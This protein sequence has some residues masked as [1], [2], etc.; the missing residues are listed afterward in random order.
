MSNRNDDFD[1]LFNDD[2]DF[3]QDDD[4][5]FRG[6]DLGDDDLAPAEYDI[7][8][9]DTFGGG[10][11]VDLDA[12]LFNEYD[13]GGDNIDLNL[14]DE[15]AEDGGR[16]PIF[17]IAAVLLVLVI[18]GGGGVL[19]FTLLNNNQQS[20]TIEQTR[21]A[22]LATNQAVEA[23]LTQT[24]QAVIS[25]RNATATADAFTDT[26]TP[27]LTPSDTPTPT[28][29]VGGTQTAI[30]I[31]T[32][33]A[34]ASS[35]ALAQSIQQTAAANLNATLTAQAGTAIAQNVTPPTM[36]PTLTPSE[37]PEG[38]TPTPQDPTPTIEDEPNGGVPVGAV[39]QTATALALILRPD[40]ITPGVSTP[41]GGRATPTPFAD[42]PNTGIFDDVVGTDPSLIMLLAFGLLGVIFVSRGLRVA[43]RK[44]K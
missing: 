41:V 40:L 10:D 32:A 37:T 33:N 9:F 38:P 12:D 13:R 1:N 24:E 20:E 43:N 17:I 34:Q 27:S 5:L 22:I 44:R 30:A 11:D 15:P 6:A 42:L 21:V 26:P 14:E 8:E 36:A 23:A 35:T 29:D 19:I 18:L 4:D 28:V 16:S 25:A 39:E 2:D 31:G 3:F 7:S